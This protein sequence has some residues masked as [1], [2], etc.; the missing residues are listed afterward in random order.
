MG[1]L[2]WD[3]QVAFPTESKLRQS[4]T[5]QPTVHAGCF[6]VLLG[7]Q[8][9]VGSILPHKATNLVWHCV[10][11]IWHYKDLKGLSFRVQ[12]RLISCWF[13]ACRNCCFLWCCRSISTLLTSP[14]WTAMA[15]L[16]CRWMPPSLHAHV[17]RPTTLLLAHAR[18]AEMPASP[19]HLPHH[20]PN[21]SRSCTLMATS[22]SWAASTWRS[23]LCLAVTSSATT[24]LFRWVLHP[25]FS[26]AS[27]WSSSLPLSVIPSVTHHY[28]DSLYL[29]GGPDMC[30]SYFICYIIM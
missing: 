29:P 18:T 28:P 15:T 26:S 23:W 5:T 10:L 25:L 22:S 2:P 9:G 14:L 7:T 11:K 13:N 12:Q 1:F 4:G 6:T 16:W 20:L 27:T 19:P 30:G 8:G 3:I 24:S 17:P 21:P